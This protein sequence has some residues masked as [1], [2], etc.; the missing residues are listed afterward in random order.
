MY[1]RKYCR[2][3]VPRRRD[4]S[5]L[6]DGSQ[7][8]SNWC[9]IYRVINW[10]FIEGEFTP[11]EHLLAYTDVVLFHKAMVVVCTLH[12]EPWIRVNRAVYLMANDCKYEMGAFIPKRWAGKITC[13]LSH[14]SYRP[15]Y[16]DKVPKDEQ[17][18]MYTFS[19]QISCGQEDLRFGK[20]GD[21]SYRDEYTTHKLPNI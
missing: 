8:Q 20:T 5:L 1:I 3:I 17:P 16:K 9:V 21:F 13:Q 15:L 18:Y 7:L 6:T 12:C 2:K 11:L 19:S 14:S 10:G 4:S